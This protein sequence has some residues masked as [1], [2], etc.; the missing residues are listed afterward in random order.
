MCGGWVP[1][2]GPVP[3]AVPQVPVREGACAGRRRAWG[4]AVTVAG[5][6][7][8]GRGEEARGPR[9]W[10]GGAG[11]ASFVPEEGTSPPPS[12]LP[13]KEPRPCGRRGAERASA[14]FRTRRGP[15]SRFQDL[16]SC[17]CRP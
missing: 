4:L 11:A 8:A 6:G 16:A 15:P 13:R 2:R 17:G 14:R 1:V 5:P 3:A 7:T 12:S 10:G 9:S